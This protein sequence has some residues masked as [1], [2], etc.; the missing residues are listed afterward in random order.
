M[1]GALRRDA[2]TACPR[3]PLGTALQ[4]R[5]LGRTVVPE[6]RRKKTLKALAGALIAAALVVAPMVTT[7]ASATTLKGE[8]GTIEAQTP[9]GNNTPYWEERYADYDVKC[10]K[11]GGDAGA[12]DHGTVS[13]DRKTVTLKQFNQD[14]WG[15]GWV[16]LVINA[17]TSNNVIENPKAD[18]AYASPENNGGQQANVSHWIVCK[19]TPPEQQN[20]AP[21]QDLDCVAIT[22]DYG[23]ALTNG[24]HINITYDEAKKKQVNAS[25]DLNVAGG[26]NTLGIRFSDGSTKP[27]TESDV[28]S[29]K[30]S[31]AYSE[32]IPTSSYAISFVQTNDTDTWPNLECGQDEQPEVVIPSLTYTPGTCL[33]DGTVTFSANAD[34]TSTKTDEDGNPIWTAAP[35]AGTV[36]AADAV[37][38]WPVP[39]LA[40][41][42]VDAEDCRPAK[43][44]VTPETSTTTDFECGSPTA[45]VTTTTTTPV[46]EWDFE[47]HHWVLGTPTT[48]TTTD[49]RP[50]SDDELATCP[51]D[52]TVKTTSWTDG[53]WECGD[54]TVAQTRTVTTLV[55]GVVTDSKTE[56]RTRD[57]AQDE[58]GTCPLVPGDIESVCV[59]DVPYLS[60]EVTLPEGFVA[61]SAKPVTI[62]FVNPDGDDY[63]VTK[64]P[65]S[66]K[67]LWPGASDEEP[68]MWPGWDL[69]DGQ[70]VQTDGNFAWTREGVTV[71]FDVNPTYST[72]VVYPKA[73][74]LCANPPV[75]SGEEPEQP[76]VPTETPTDTPSGT[77]S[78]TPVPAA[79]GSDGDLAVTGGG[80][81]PI[82]VAA[83]GVTLAAGVAV[84]AIAAYRRRRAGAE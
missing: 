29:G 19:G 67:L 26:W 8:V 20:P 49:E 44:E 74:A 23:R 59:S 33:A 60:Y 84:V 37:V 39:S 40:K 66:G 13:A 7:G 75:G 72:E 14:W 55:D 16:V 78:A 80:V 24:D 70:Y 73:S 64:Q 4:R 47:T 41:L 57:L 12:Y 10:Y 18:V 15:T 58:I 5:Y 21:T 77:P 61:S 81:S 68:K 63:V 32:L 53:T 46:Y 69:V 71:R 3:A 79:V 35:K 30:I 36:F 9:K 2:S 45:V 11:H 62:T 38:D 31:W 42:S 76:G 83:G 65:L 52:T 50:L 28:K 51:P 34:W 27:L 54:T 1:Y 6:A 48:V 82:V 22:V 25:V 17:G 56:T 43:P